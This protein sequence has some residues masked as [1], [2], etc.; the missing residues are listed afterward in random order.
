MFEDVLIF[1]LLISRWISYSERIHFSLLK[2]VLWPSMYLGGCFKCTWKNMY[3]ALVGWNV[4]EMSINSSCLMLLSIFSISIL[5]F[6]I[7]IFSITERS[8]AFVFFLLQLWICL[9]YFQ[10]YK[11][12]LH[13]LELCCQVHMYL[14]CYVFL[15]NCPLYQ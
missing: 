12:V 2:F 5:I 8:V 13:F 11:L 9:F 10:F 4:L 14:D 1:F 15:A 7:L 3:S 6:Y